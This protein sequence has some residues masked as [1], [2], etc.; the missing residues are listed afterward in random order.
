MKPAVTAIIFL[1]SLCS[2]AMGQDYLFQRYQEA[3][4]PAN[5]DRFRLAFY[6]LEN[7]FDL[8][9]DSLTFDEAFTPEGENG[10]TFSRYKKKSTGLA[11]TLAAVGGWQPADII[12]LCEVESR[13]VMEGLTIHSPLKKLGYQIVHEDSPDRRGIDV[14]CIYRP[15]R[16]NLI[17]Y[18]YYRIHFPD[19]PDRKTRDMLY[20]KGIL[21][22][23][24][25]LHVFV[26]HWPSRYGGQFSSEPSRAYVASVL[27]Q[28]VDSLNKRFGNPLIAI[29]GDFND[30]PDDLSL[31]E[32]LKAQTNPA[33]ARG[34]DLV[35]LSA[36]IKYKFGTHSFAGE[37]GVLDHFIVSNSLLT[38]QKTST[39]PNAVGVFDAPWL[40]TKNAAGNAVPLR[41]FQGPAYKGGY[42][43]HLPIFLDI[44]LVTENNSGAITE[45]SA[46]KIKQ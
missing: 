36:P 23:D 32:T 13:W 45:D 15:E 6:N 37:W 35:N 22:N 41:T 5:N 29:C 8:N 31:V 19:D 11:R 18:T 21:P 33:A 28:K 14:A 20:L 4:L 3:W 10:Y 43:D 7:L 2:A 38:G 24:D 39:R 30:E 1:L 46:A 27:R 12:G 40:L 44:Y 42:S 26:N 34:N 17:R 25:T 16:F 9:D